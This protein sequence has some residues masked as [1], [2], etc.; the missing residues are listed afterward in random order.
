M[1]IPEETHNKDNFIDYLAFVGVGEE[2]AAG[3][4]E[5]IRNQSGTPGDYSYFYSYIR[6]KKSIYEHLM[7]I[8]Y[9]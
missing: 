7:E 4:S 5:R 6:G 2:E 8:G 9:D 3:I 1:F